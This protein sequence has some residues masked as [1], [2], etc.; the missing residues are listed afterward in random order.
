MSK[1]TVTST[2]RWACPL[3]RFVMFDTTRELNEQDVTDHHDSGKGKPYCAGVPKI[4]PIASTE[5]DGH[6]T[7]KY[8]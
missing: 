2:I 4:K 8:P 1:A 5:N 7:G 3:C 6:P